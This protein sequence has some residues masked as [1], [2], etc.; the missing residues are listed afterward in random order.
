MGHPSRKDPTLRES[1]LLILSSHREYEKRGGWRE[2]PRMTTQNLR[3]ETEPTKDEERTSF[4]LLEQVIVTLP[5]TLKLRDV[6]VY[7]IFTTEQHSLMCH[8]MK[9]KLLCISHFIHIPFTVQPLQQLQHQN[10]NGSFWKS[11]RKKKSKRKPIEIA[12]CTTDQVSNNNNKKKRQD[13]FW[14]WMLWS[15]HVLY[16]FCIGCRRRRLP[17]SLVNE[18]HQSLPPTT[19]LPSLLICAEYEERR[20]EPEPCAYRL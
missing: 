13:F 15:F 16:W 10:A 12:T 11:K 8:L 18:H 5:W 3:G 2:K 7:F 14:H 20:M 19:P 9:V 1:D 4:I 6:I 17:Q